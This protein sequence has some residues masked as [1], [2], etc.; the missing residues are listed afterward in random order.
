MSRL[1]VILVTDLQNDV[2]ALL[3][4]Y[5]NREKNVTGIV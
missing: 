2:S 1:S 5:L 4:W 3:R